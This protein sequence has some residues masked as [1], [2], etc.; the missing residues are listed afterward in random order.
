MVMFP[1][2]PDPLGH[3]VVVELDVSTRLV[4]SGF[5]DGSPDVDLTEQLPDLVLH[6]LRL[7]HR[8]QQGTDPAFDARGDQVDVADLQL[9]G[10]PPTFVYAHPGTRHAARFGWDEASEHVARAV[11]DLI[12]SGVA[13]DAADDVPDDISALPDEEGDVADREPDGDSPQSREAPAD[14]DTPPWLE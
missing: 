8:A 5:A 6:G 1:S 14:T 12:T 11:A 4:A 13:A 7:S 9:T 10:P 2:G 3:V